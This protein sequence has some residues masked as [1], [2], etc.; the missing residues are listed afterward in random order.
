MRTSVRVMTVLFRL[1]ELSLARAAVRPHIQHDVRSYLSDVELLH[2]AAVSSYFVRH[3]RVKLT[4]MLSMTAT[5]GLAAA[6]RHPPISADTT[7]LPG[8][9]E[10]IDSSPRL[11]VHASEPRCIASS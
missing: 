7:I 9:D 3:A 1:D 4:A 8:G 2:A 6:T 10:K 11:R 5:R